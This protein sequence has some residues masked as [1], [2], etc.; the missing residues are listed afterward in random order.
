M[1]GATAVVSYVGRVVA[2][3]VDA[4]FV[5]DTVIFASAE[6][7]HNPKQFD[8]RLLA[9]ITSPRRHTSQLLPPTIL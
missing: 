2:S 8:C 5:F 6:S 3:V 9:G 4:D 7:I 1:I